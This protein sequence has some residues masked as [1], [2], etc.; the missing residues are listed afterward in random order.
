MINLR[1]ANDKVCPWSVVC[2]DEVRACVSFKDHLH[3]HYQSK[4]WC[5]QLFHRSLGIVVAL[6]KVSEK[7][8]RAALLRA[9]YRD[10][11]EEKVNYKAHYRHVLVS[12][13]FESMYFIHLFV[14]N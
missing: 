2:D 14:D 3:S 7:E 1:V 9:I 11:V 10:D 5:T 13:S 4:L 6:G 8:A 12:L